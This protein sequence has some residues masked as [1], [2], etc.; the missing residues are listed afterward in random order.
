MGAG[1]L[2]FRGPVP[3]LNK[4]QVGRAP[5]TVGRANRP[6]FDLPPTAK[7]ARKPPKLA[8]EPAL[9]MASLT[10]RR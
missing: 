8:Q 4:A 2:R 1:G 3:A 7:P 9:V 6:P 5:A 10:A